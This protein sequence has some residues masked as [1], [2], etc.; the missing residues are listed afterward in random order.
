MPQYFHKIMVAVDWLSLTLISPVKLSSEEVTV[1]LD[2]G[3]DNV[4]VNKRICRPLGHE[5]WI[6][7]PRKYGTKQFRTIWEISYIDEGGCMSPFGILCSD[8]TTAALDPCMCTLKLDN[9]LLYREGC[10]QWLDMLRIWLADYQMKILHISRCDLA[11]DFIKLNNRI[12]GAQLVDKIKSL[13]WWKCGSTK[14]AEYYKLPYEDVQDSWGQ[15]PA[16]SPK[17][18]LQRGAL[19]TRVESMTFGTMSSDAQVCV[20][21][22]TLELKRTE[23]EIERGGQIIRES[24]KEY[25]RDCHKLAGVYDEK[26]HTW[27]VEIRLRQ[28]SLFISDPAYMSD[29]AV[30]LNDLEP[31][32]LY[33]TFVAAADRYFKLVDPTC[34][35][36]NKLTAEYCR[37]MSTHKNRLPIVKLFPPATMVM[38]FTKKKY[39]QCANQFHRSVIK[40]LD[41]LA[42]RSARVC[43][44]YSKPGDKELLPELL[45]RL[46]PIASAMEADRKRI[47][48]AIIAVGSVQS[49]LCSKQAGVSIEDI[50][51]VE[52]CR[53][54]LERHYNQE[55]PQFVRRMVSMLEKYSNKMLP[56]SDVSKDVPLRHVR[57][58]APSD[59]QI[60]LDAA[61][62]LKAVYVD[63]AYDDRRE[64]TH[65]LYAQSFLDCIN[66]VNQSPQPLPQCLDYLYKMVESTRYMTEED[67]TTLFLPHRHSNFAM[68]IKCNW[69]V[70]LWAHNLGYTKFE[71][72]WLPPMLPLAETRALTS[73]LISLTL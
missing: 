57:A 25:I 30:Q 71:V 31:H 17:V 56:I 20:Y 55:S 3:I 14:V 7:E 64:R 27:R 29:R 44:K 6:W 70:G 35:G 49:L 58:A 68:L 8:P 69:D 38:A 13:E 12:S 65:D 21:D 42:A 33:N 36:A 50:K 32:K 22:K 47:D 10:S 1:S 62:I 67:I 34:G 41:E 59:S 45:Q 73:K 24:A 43:A 54:M 48:A 2:G 15:D 40:R 60:L 18:Y 46:G 72:S 11:A 23:V 61:D 9:S 51:L 5:Q 66:H 19:R 37:S 39:H 28:K 53:D 4:T 52:S 26:R 63:V 16:N